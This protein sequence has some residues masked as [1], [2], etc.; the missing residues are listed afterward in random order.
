L[1]FENYRGAAKS[2]VALF[3]YKKITFVFNKIIIT[4]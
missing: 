2:K 1:K 4:L 3:F